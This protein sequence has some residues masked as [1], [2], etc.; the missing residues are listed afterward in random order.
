MYLTLAK[1]VASILW[2]CLLGVNLSVVFLNFLNSSYLGVSLLICRGVICFLI[3]FYKAGW[4]GAIFFLI[5]VG[6]V[7]VLLLYITSLNFNPLFFMK[8]LSLVGCLSLLV[9]TTYIGDISGYLWTIVEKDIFRFDLVKEEEVIFLLN[10]GL[11][12]LLVLWVISKL[13]YS[14]KGPLRAIF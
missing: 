5:Y 11:L 8:K 14:R 13:I 10:I 9:S 12:L 1:M 2:F 7:L 4:F 6:G 3:I